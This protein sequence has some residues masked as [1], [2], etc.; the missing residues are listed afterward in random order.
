LFLIEAFHSTL[1]ETALSDAIILVIDFH[2]SLGEICR[3]L[4][5]CID[6]LNEIGVYGI[7]LVTVLNKIDLMPIDEIEEKMAALESWHKTP[8]L[9][10]LFWQNIEELKQKIAECLS[11]SY[12]PPLNSP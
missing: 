4:S 5:C 10:R 3:K 6:T 11:V 2:E 12:K 9:F 1:E 8:T 7:P